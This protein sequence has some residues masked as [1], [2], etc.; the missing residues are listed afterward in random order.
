MELVEQRPGKTLAHIVDAL[1]KAILERQEGIMVKS[2]D[3]P[4]VPNERKNAW[5]KIK[6]EYAGSVGDDLDLVILG[7]FY[8]TG[9]GRRGGTI[10]HFLVGV[11][12]L[13]GPDAGKY[14]T[15]AKV[16]SGYNDS[17]LLDIQHLFKDAWRN[18]DRER[19]PPDILFAPS[20]NKDKPDVWLAPAH[21]RIV[22][23]RASQIHESD[24][25][26]AGWTLRFPRVYKFRMDKAPDEC[27]DL[28][29]L[30]ELA[31]AAE[32]RYAKRP[33]PN[34]DAQVWPP[35]PPSPSS[36]PSWRLTSAGQ[37]AEG[38]EAA[39]YCATVSAG[40][41]E[42]RRGHLALPRRPRVLGSFR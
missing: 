11:A 26:R 36:C 15:L 40:G 7:G 3:S 2:L 32:G 34:G 14:Y 9:Q 28:D 16:G 41:G 37:E 5:L 6:P 27:L 42:H 20:S 24:K 17:T 39:A 4:Y 29:S 22:Q 10:S 12:V 31:R 19:P 21:S 33:L 38:A 1:D 13:H 25:Y 23:V 30:V 8:G 35:L 18:F